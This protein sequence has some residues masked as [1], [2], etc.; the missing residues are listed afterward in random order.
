MSS[1]IAPAALLLALS[2]FFSAAGAAAKPPSV[3]VTIKPIHS[4]AAG[5]MAGVATPK[6]LI[7]GGGSPHSYSLRPSDARAL[8][9][10]G[11]VVW[12]GEGLE[13]FMKKPLAALGTNA[14]IL[15]LA[16]AEGVKLLPSRSGGAWENS[17]EHHD[18]HDHGEA[19]GESFDY[20]I[21]LDP[22]NARAIVGQIAAEL[23]RL[24]PAN[25]NAYQAN[26]R[27]LDERLRGLDAEL[28]NRL[29][30]INQI[31]YVVF[32]DGYQPL[33]KR[34][35]L[36]AV[37]AIT[38]SPDRKPG[39]RRL[40]EIRSTITSLGAKCVFSEP[41]FEPRLVATVTEGTGARAGILDPLGADLPAGAEAYFE[42]MRNLA[43]YLESCL[44]GK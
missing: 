1:R 20:H 29:A 6:L 43:A 13:S 11:L 32:H 3:V 36:N 28:G 26:A 44:A 37:G 31:P 16:Q 34:Y 39:A 2:I 9:E 4:L 40:R 25:S 10:A 35:S 19:H 12:V 5:V 22:A 15:T 24:D 14:R 33:E 18:G 42:L 7:E 38:V 27:Q 21:W 8:S 30:P 17:V 41:Q 23:G